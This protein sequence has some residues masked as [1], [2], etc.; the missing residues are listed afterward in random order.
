MLEVRRQDCF[1]DGTVFVSLYVANL[2]LASVAGGGNAN[3][4]A[5]DGCKML[6]TLE[7]H[8]QCDVED[9]KVVVSQQVLTAIHAKS[10]H[11][12][13]RARTCADP[14]LMGKVRST[15]SCSGREIVDT[16]LC[17]NILSHEFQNAAEFPGSQAAA[18]AQGGCRNNVTAGG[19]EQSSLFHVS[20]VVTDIDD[21]VSS[22]DGKSRSSSGSD[23]TV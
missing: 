4:L 20:P 10:A 17:S 9:G 18:V 23:S 16:N 19:N 7:P 14:K 6:L 15:Q 2:K 3:N 22:A 13:V 5:E 12:L 8:R 1:C 11:I 21:R